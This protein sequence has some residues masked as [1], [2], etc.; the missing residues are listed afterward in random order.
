M[1]MQVTLGKGASDKETTRAYQTVQVLISPREV[2]EAYLNA[3]GPRA[4][5]FAYLSK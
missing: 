5:K 3:E 2:G 4:A 1:Q